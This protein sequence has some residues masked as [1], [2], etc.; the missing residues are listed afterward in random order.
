MQSEK[1]TQI[2]K[3]NKQFE[4]QTQIT[5]KNSEVEQAD[6]CKIKSAVFRKMDKLAQ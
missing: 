2:I 6:C 1:Q 5:K 3:K 4:K